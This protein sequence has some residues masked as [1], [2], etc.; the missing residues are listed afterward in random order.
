MTMKPVAWLMAGVLLIAA[1]SG[2]S[3]AQT[4]GGSSLDPGMPLPTGDGI[5]PEQLSDQPASPNPVTGELVPPPGPPPEG[6][7]ADIQL[8][9]CA[10][11]RCGT[12]QIMAP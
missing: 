5:P 8:P 9:D 6:A 10:P 12:P 4:T 3:I 11:P 7:A 1:V 2:P